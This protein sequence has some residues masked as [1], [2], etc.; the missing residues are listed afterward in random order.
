MLYQVN[1]N[2]RRKRR[3]P[4][5]PESSYLVQV[6]HRSYD[7]TQSGE[8]PALA[9][10]EEREESRSMRDNSS[11]ITESMSNETHTLGPLPGETSENMDKSGLTRFFVL[12]VFLLFSCLVV[13]VCVCV[14]VRACVCVCVCVYVRACVCVCDP[15]LLI[16]YIDRVLEAGE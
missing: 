9:T 1:A 16:G 15:I 4:Q 14:C 6:Q 5:Q 10:K 11:P 12:L 2:R 7:S 13:S 8:R 3:Q